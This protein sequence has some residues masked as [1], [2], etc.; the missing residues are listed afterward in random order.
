ME[1]VPTTESDYTVTGTSS[2][3]TLY[4]NQKPQ[5]TPVTITAIPYY[6]W[7]NRGETNMR[8]WIPER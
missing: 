3:N 7:G 1:D 6:T 5:R 4:S 8:V 2:G